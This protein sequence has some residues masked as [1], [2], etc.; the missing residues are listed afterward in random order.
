MKKYIALF[1]LLLIPVLL[2]ATVDEKDGVAITTATDMDGFTG[3]IGGV[4][5]G[6]APAGGGSCEETPSVSNT[7][8]ADY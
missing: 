3:A 4:D 2:W 1:L 8:D 6:G 5:G 7:V